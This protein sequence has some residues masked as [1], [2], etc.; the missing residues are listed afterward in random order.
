[1]DGKFGGWN[2]GRVDRS[3]DFSLLH[4]Q[5]ELS[6]AGI[7]FPFALTLTGSD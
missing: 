5:K 1:M 2:S 3:E 7:A 6:F 4:F